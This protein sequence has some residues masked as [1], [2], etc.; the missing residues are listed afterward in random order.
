M[1]I[2]LYLIAVSNSFTLLLERNNPKV[3]G[4]SWILLHSV[5]GFPYIEWLISKIDGT[6]E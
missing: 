2:V 6:Q 3:V 1:Y 5:T 4:W